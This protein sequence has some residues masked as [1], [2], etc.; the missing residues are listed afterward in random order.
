MMLTVQGLQTIQ[1]EQHL[2]SEESQ[3][4]VKGGLSLNIIVCLQLLASKDQPLLIRGN[5]LLVLNFGVN[6]V[7]GFGG[8]SSVSL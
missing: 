7:N 5:A 2:P 1:Q 8:L 6:I 3:D 4:Q